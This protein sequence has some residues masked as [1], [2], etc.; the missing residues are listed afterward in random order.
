MTH[1]QRLYMGN[2]DANNKSKTLF[3]DF[4]ECV[5]LN[6]DTVNAAIKRDPIARNVKLSV[7]GP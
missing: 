6:R 4:N 1:H 5:A 7:R 2:D 3:I